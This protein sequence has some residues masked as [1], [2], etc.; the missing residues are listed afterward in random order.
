MTRSGLSAPPLQTVWMVTWPWAP[1]AP[2][3]MVLLMTSSPVRYSSARLAVTDPPGGI[4]TLAPL[5][6]LTTVIVPVWPSCVS[7][8]VQ[9]EPPA[10]PVYVCDGVPVA[11]AAMTNGGCSVVASPL[12]RQVTVIVIWP[13]CPAPG[14][15]IVLVTVSD[16]GCC[17]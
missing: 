5:P 9:T 11:P 1:A 16:P 17:W 15:V 7:T 3:V 4:V 12:D 13:C 10:M 14:P 6:L 8:T 2:P